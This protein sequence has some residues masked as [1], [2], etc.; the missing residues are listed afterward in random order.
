MVYFCRNINFGSNHWYRRKSEKKISMDF[1]RNILRNEFAII[2]ISRKR[3]QSFLVCL[4]FYLVERHTWWIHTSIYTHLALFNIFIKTICCG[5]EQMTYIRMWDYQIKLWKRS[6]HT[7]S[8]FIY[9]KSDFT[10]ALDLIP[11]L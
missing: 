9:T 3:T 5:T 11:K 7:N 1:S 4:L 2:S 10:H 8:L 6:F